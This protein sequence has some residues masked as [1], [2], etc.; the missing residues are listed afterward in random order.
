MK[1]LIAVALMI[2]MTGC[3]TESQQ[4]KTESTVTGTA[5]GAI[6]GGIIGGLLGGKRGAVIGAATG[7]VIGGVAGYSYGD[8]IAQRHQELEGKENDLNAR[9]NFARGVNQDT[10]EYNQKL[11][12]EIAST[13][14]GVD[15]LAAQIKR[16]QVTQQQ[17]YTAREQL[18][19][20]VN[21]AQQQLTVAQT[22]LHN[23]Q[24]FKSKQPQQSAE[25]NTEISRLQTNLAQL[26]SNTN[27]LAA[28]SQRI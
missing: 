3:A 2:A 22:E 25:L 14:Q 4:A 26:K 19:A 24:V 8:K 11:R 23:L 10:E 17:L 15:A 28:L 21:N 16:Q 27:T 1:K 13:K 20:K 7:G 12:Q 5:I 18:N 9:I 6:A